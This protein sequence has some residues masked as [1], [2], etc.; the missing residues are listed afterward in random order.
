MPF[1]FDT[2]II[3]AMMRREPNLY[4]TRRLASLPAEEQSTSAI[5]YGE[6][7][8]GA[9][10]RNRQDLLTSIRVITS[11]MPIRPFDER[12]AERF[13]DLKSSL[14]RAG[15]PLDE[16]D[17]RIAAIALVNGLTLVTGN[18]RHFR[19]VPELAVENWL[20]PEER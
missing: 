19:R 8:Y 7:L 5:S 11:Q 9:L 2:D 3:S 14:E 16:P 12:A 13:A 17:L 18:E 6:L 15:T 1:L 4:V 10:R 20:L